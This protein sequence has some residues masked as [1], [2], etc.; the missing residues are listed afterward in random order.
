[1]KVLGQLNNFCN[2]ERKLLSYAI[3]GMIIILFVIS[4]F[5]LWM[6]YPY[7]DGLQ[8]DG[9]HYLK[10]V[11]QFNSS[12][13]PNFSFIGVGYPFFI[14]VTTLG[15]SNPYLLVLAQQLLTLF[16]VLLLFKTFGKTKYFWVVSIFC[17]IHIFND[18]YVSW[19]TTIFPDSLI[20]N[21]FLISF[22]IYFL[23]QTTK[24]RKYYV[25]L[26]ILFAF[27]I[28]IRSSNIFL[29]GV[30]IV[31]FI[32]DYINKK[33][34]MYY[35]LFT[36]GGI[37]ISYSSYNFLFSEPGKFSFLSYTR[38]DKYFFK[39][40]N[41]ELE[42]ISFE[43]INELPNES[44]LA[45][46][47]KPE[48]V[49]DYYFGYR[50]TRDTITISDFKSDSIEICGFD[51]TGMGKISYCT[52]IKNH[53][54]NQNLSE[55]DKIYMER[56]LHFKK[57]KLYNLLSVPHTINKRSTSYYARTQLL[58]NQF[59]IDNKKTDKL[60][61]SNLCFKLY[62]IFSTK[63]TN[64][65]Y[66]SSLLIVFFVTAIIFYL[67]MSIKIK[68]QNQFYNVILVYLTFYLGNLFIYGLIGFPLLR[69]T[70]TFEFII[71][72]LVLF[73][74]SDFSNILMSLKRKYSYV[75]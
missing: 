17:L 18:N 46:R 33:N 67:W 68:L 9:V 5:G 74:M 73:F 27:L 23:A 55:I 53:W 59:D 39:S 43:I 45:K 14:W 60:L 42:K 16:S 41:S 29:F 6:Y 10:V 36:L 49:E 2:K 32:I 25:L 13:I 57:N 24:K 71:P 1:M 48:S 72:L 26:G 19:E 44:V 12:E 34:G 15:Y 51:D 3:T 38:M 37:L 52:I 65:I 56:F 30:V 28:M 8:S 64:K 58:S 61:F 63:I 54:K 50:V 22:S 62:D 66:R 47:Y 11:N 35:L 69:Y 20:K 4:R 40:S 70:L 75:E 31:M 7:I 21:L